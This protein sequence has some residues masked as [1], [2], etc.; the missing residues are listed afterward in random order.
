MEAGPGGHDKA[1][2]SLAHIQGDPRC[3]WVLLL[4]ILFF[5]FTPAIRSRVLIPI[6]QLKLPH[7]QECRRRRRQ[8]NLP[9]WALFIFELRKTRGDLNS[10]KNV[11]HYHNPTVAHSKKLKSSGHCCFKNSVYEKNI[12]WLCNGILCV[13]D[14]PRTKVQTTFERLLF[15][16]SSSSLSS[17]F[18]LLVSHSLVVVIFGFWAHL[19]VHSCSWPPLLQSSYT[20]SRVF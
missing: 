11:G 14:W 12:S 18:F 1:S 8:P 20:Q 9:N 15:T 5:A 7:T 17:S 3:V 4:L 16:Y 13:P 2:L 6:S 10:V 19:T